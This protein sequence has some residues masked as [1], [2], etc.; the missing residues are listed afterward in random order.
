MPYEG[1]INKI[2]LSAHQAGRALVAV[3]NYRYNDFKPYIYLTDDYGKNWQLLTNGN[4]IPE[5]HFVRAVAEDPAQKGLLYAGTEY[6]M[7]LSFDN[8]KNWQP[9]QLNL[10]VTPITDMEVVENDLVISTQG[11][12]FWVLDDLTPLHQLSPKQSTSKNMFFQPR[13]AIRTSVDDYHARLHF[14]LA[15]SPDKKEPVT[16]T[17]KDPGGKVI[18][19]LSTKADNRLNKIKVSKGFNTIQWDLRHEGPE[20]VGNLVAMVI[21]NPS[22]GPYAVPGN[23]QVSIQAGNWSESQN[24]QI[25]PDPRWT[26]VQQADYEAQLETVLAIRDMITDAHKRIKNLRALREQMKSISDLAVRAGHS[27][28]LQEMSS[29]ISEKLVAIEDQIIQNKAEASQDNINY[30]RVFTNH[31]GRLYGVAMNAHHRPTGG[32]LER[33]EDIKAEYQGIIDQYNA[34]V[35]QE[36]TNYNELLE[37]EKISGLIVPEKVK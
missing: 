23:Y 5:D 18:R 7:Y 10:P 28:K 29:N 8:G 9:F 14:Y 16:I 35:D 2:E 37:K 6:G 19:T 11:R 31:I 33:W 32:V 27:E 3:Y 34:V 30:P 4:G 17:I 36:I 1:T 25:Q 24:L 20:L 26:H 12:A 15:K 13:P 22:P 21:R